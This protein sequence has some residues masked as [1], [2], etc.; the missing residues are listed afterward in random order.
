MAE[1]RLAVHLSL[2]LIVKQIYGIN[3]TLLIPNC[4]K[5][6]YLKRQPVGYIKGDYKNALE[7]D[8]IFRVP[9]VRKCLL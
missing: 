2:K 8:I 4:A 9:V 1:R 6:Y 5:G 3:L 7:A